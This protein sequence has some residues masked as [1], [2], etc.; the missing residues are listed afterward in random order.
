MKKM[1][2]VVSD[3]KKFDYSVLYAYDTVQYAT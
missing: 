1:K 3:R 2:V